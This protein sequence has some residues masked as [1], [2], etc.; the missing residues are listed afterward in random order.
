MDRQVMLGESVIY[1]DPVARQFSALVTAVWS[2]TCINLVLVSG[3]ES[4]GDTYGRQIERQT[5]MPH[6]SMNSAHGHYWMFPGEEPN[7]IQRPLQS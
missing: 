3:D 6:K 1:V 4:K 7:P 5:S 2:P